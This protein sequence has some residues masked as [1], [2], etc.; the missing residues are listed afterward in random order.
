LATALAG[1]D[2]DAASN[3]HRRVHRQYRMAA[4]RETPASGEK[5]RD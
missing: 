5:R 1:L 3:G 2:C 4:A